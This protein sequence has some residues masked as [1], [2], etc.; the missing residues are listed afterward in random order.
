MLM[1]RTAWESEEGRWAPLP[2]ASALPKGREP[3]GGGLP[4][5]H[6]AQRAGTYDEERDGSAA[7]C[8]SGGVNISAYWDVLALLDC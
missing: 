7:H 2:L 1:L 5:E 3:F 8:S 6:G 4:S